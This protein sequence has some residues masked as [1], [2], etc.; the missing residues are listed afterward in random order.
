MHRAFS[1]KVHY[2]S[3]NRPESSQY[4][5]YFLSHRSSFNI[6]LR[7]ALKHLV[8]Y[9]IDHFRDGAT[10]TSVW[11]LPVAQSYIVL[12]CDHNALYFT[13]TR[14]WGYRPPS[15]YCISVNIWWDTRHC[16]NGI[17]VG[18]LLFIMKMASCIQW[19]RLCQSIPGPRLGHCSQGGHRGRRV[20]V[21]ERA[22]VGYLTSLRCT[23]WVHFAYWV[24][25]IRK[26][27]ICMQKVLIWSKK[28]GTQYIMDST[29]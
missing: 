10:K 2:I 5:P 12:S 13:N 11:L 26:L 7:I 6:S 9:C 22:Y 29:Q 23:S 21:R 4:T 28:W 18:E 27:F 14:K 19:I 16:N 20:R 24:Y 1:Y 17:F 25:P 3:F 8:I 15:S